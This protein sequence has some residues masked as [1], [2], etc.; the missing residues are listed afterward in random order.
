MQTGN[1]PTETTFTEIIERPPLLFLD[2]EEPLHSLGLLNNKSLGK[3][4]SDHP[5]IVEKHG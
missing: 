4:P 5:F 1:M 3:P 2:I